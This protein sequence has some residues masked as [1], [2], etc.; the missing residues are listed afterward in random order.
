[1]RLLEIC[2]D[3]LQSALNAQSGGAHRIELCENLY[4]GGVTPSAAKIK[5]AAERLHIPVF[6]LIRPRKGDFLYSAPEF[7]TMLEDVRIAQHLGASGIVSGTLL[8]D[9]DIDMDRT[10]LLVEAAHPL[11]FTFHRAFDMCREPLRAIDQLAAA[12]VRHI[13]SSGQQP[14]AALGLNN[15]RRFARYA[16]NRITVMA[17][18]GLLPDNIGPLLEI[19]E[20][21]AFHAAAR[22]RVRSEMQFFGETNMGDEAVEEEFQWHETDA[23]I[24]AGLREAMEGK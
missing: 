9:G 6:V 12:G 7:D 17:C 21:Q 13:L 22:R 16:G 18:G 5:L 19:E 11:P 15:L 20:L 8:P 10:R 1:M 24:V 2:V 23:E 4:Q 3:S 14:S